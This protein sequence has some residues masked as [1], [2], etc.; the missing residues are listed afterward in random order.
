MGMVLKL[1]AGPELKAMEVIAAEVEKRPVPVSAEEK[2]RKKLLEEARQRSTDETDRL[3]KTIRRNLMRDYQKRRRAASGGYE[4][5]LL[6]GP[7]GIQP[8]GGEGK[9][10]LG[11]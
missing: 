9:K 6:T 7:S 8:L 3:R 2:E 5:T 11:L 4:G 10:S 1:F